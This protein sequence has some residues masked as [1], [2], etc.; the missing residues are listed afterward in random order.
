[1]HWLLGCSN[2][3]L[4]GL[5]LGA[6]KLAMLSSI[7]T[8]P[9]SL[10]VGVCVQQDATGA[11]LELEKQSVTV[12]V[13]WKCWPQKIPPRAL[14]EI[15]QPEGP[16]LVATTVTCFG[17]PACMNATLPCLRLRIYLHA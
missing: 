12:R 4:W 13:S 5:S 7:K 2:C 14:P 8:A 6:L 17:Q 1:M 10:L 16:S 9:A 11:C 3:D 15:A